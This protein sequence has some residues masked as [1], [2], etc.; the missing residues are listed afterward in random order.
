MIFRGDSVVISNDGP[1]DGLHG[2]VLSTTEDEHGRLI[3]ILLTEGR[4]IWCPGDKIELSAYEVKQASEDSTTPFIIDQG[5]PGWL[6]LK[7][8][9]DV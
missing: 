1:L 4:G 6:P 7:L 8:R 3:S 2:E 9:T 5:Q